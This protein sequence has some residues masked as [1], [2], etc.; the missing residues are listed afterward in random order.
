M[1]DSVSAAP[2]FEPDGR[3]LALSSLVETRQYAPRV[4]ATHKYA[5]IARSIAAIGLVEPLVV[6]PEPGNTGSYFLLDGHLRVA[7]LR[8]AGHADALCLI[9]TDDEAFTYNNRV[10]RLTAA[11]EHRMISRAVERGVPEQVLADVLGLEPRTVRRKAQ[12]L[13]GIAPAAG[14]L[15]ARADCPLAVYETLRRMTADRQVEAAALMAAQG[16]FTL[17]FAKALLAASRPEDR[18]PS[19][20][21][22]GAA[23]THE[24]MQKVQRE[25][26]GL[27]SQL[28]STDERFGLDALH[29]TLALGHISKIMQNQQ[30]YSW[31]A[32]QR[33]EY[34]EEFSAIIS[35]R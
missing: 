24:Q 11:Q 32:Y 18:R 35:D 33:P 29:F 9:S 7:A 17:P 31:L 3:V 1:L 20:R 10:N 34:L 19:R 28:K 16:R 25:L 6:R 13:R 2:A 22:S 21:T 27:Q 14:D 15:L 23:V 4:K 30:L 8:D 26:D 12:L 5:Q